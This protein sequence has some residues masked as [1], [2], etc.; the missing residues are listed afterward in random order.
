VIL[1]RDKA[2][3]TPGIQ[4]PTDIDFRIMLTFLE[5]YQTLL[6]FIF[7]KLYTDINLV[8]P[9]K[10]N[11]ATDEN[12]AGIGA[13][14]LEETSRTLTIEGAAA[15]VDGAKNL[16]KSTT[17]RD[18]K[19]Q[20]KSISQSAASAQ[21]EAEAE[22]EA[23]PPVAEGEEGSAAEDGEASLFGPYYFFLSREVT[24]PTLEFAIRSFG[25]RVG[26]DPVLGDGSPFL[27]SD[28]R[29]THHVIDRPV[30]PETAPLPSYEGK[31]AFIQPQWVVDCINVK[32]LLPTEEYAP[33]R[34][35]PPHLSPFVDA[36]EAR[37][38][39]EYVPGEST[40]R[41]GE[42]EEEEVDDD[43]EM[44]EDEESAE[45]EDVDM[46][47]DEKKK[48]KKKKKAE[49]AATT[50]TPALLAAAR[51]PDDEGLAHAAEL[52]AEAR[53]VPYA[54]FRAELKAETD[55]ARKSKAVATKES[56]ATA[57]KDGNQ[58]NIMLTGKQ[59]KLYNRMSYTKAKRAEEVSSFLYL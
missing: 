41:N 36:E 52:E 30:N 1:F 37:R 46:G 38:L 40:T 59:R 24:R 21:V 32:R 6:G 57:K 39:G 5:L 42:E 49:V 19:R 26:W 20:I 12:G 50:A 10:I 35:L 53:G 25:G 4:V 28:A 56:T 44:D 27:I 48:K 58:A 55:K 14:L 7:Y 33:G 17:A 3:I 9:P 13:F 11:D 45:E 16:S 15:T 18:V 22:A 31:R 2:E 43:E 34:T 23:A 29:I 8:Y 54:Q 47:D 51:Q